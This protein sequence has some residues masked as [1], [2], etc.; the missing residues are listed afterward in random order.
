MHV[1]YVPDT[2]ELQ[3][4]HIMFCMLKEIIGFIV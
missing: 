3:N 4:G 1:F 2:D